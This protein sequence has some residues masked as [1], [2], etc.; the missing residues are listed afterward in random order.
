VRMYASK[1]ANGW[2]LVL[3]NAFRL[4]WRFRPGRGVR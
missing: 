3:R 4:L 1:I 2:P